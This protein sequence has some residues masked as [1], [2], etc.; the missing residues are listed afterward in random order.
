[1][2]MLNDVAE[3]MQEQ[4]IKTSL[5]QERK[6]FVPS[7]VF[8]KKKSVTRTEY[9]TAGQSGLRPSAMFKVH[10]L[11]YDQE[12]YIR[13]EEKIYSIYRTF[14]NGDFIELYCEVR[15]GANQSTE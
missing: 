10:L 1:M 11:D 15:S 5:G 8:C 7:E 6:S 4:I 3:L 9:F 13:H 12:L 2:D 14:E